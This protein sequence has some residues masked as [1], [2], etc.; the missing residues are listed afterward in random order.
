MLRE[1][2]VRSIPLFRD[3]TQEQVRLLCEKCEYSEHSRDELVFNVGDPVSAVYFVVSRDGSRRTG[4]ARARVELSAVAPAKPL[5]FDRIVENELFGEFEYFCGGMRP[6]TGGGP[7]SRLIRETKASL[8]VSEPLVSL[9]LNVLS[10]LIENNPSFRQRFVALAAGRLKAAL[11]SQSRRRHVDLD[12]SLAEHL[13]DLATDYATMYESYAVF[14]TRIS[15]EDI[16][17]DLGISRRALTE[18]FGT[19][20][21]A[22]L[23]RTTPLALLDIRRLEQLQRIGLEE[24]VPLVRS[25]FEDI[26]QWIDAGELALARSMALDFMRH[27]PSSPAL[28][29]GAAL[30]AARSGSSTDA[31][32]VLAAVGLTHP[33][34]SRLRDRIAFGL[35]RPTAAVTDVVPDREDILESVED[36]EG[37]DIRSNLSVR[38]EIMRNVTHFAG[39]ILS[40]RARLAKDEA[41]HDL[42]SSQAQRASSLYIDAWQV[43]GSRNSYPL[44][45]AASMALLAGDNDRARELATKALSL[46]ASDEYWSLASRIEA[47]LVL[48]DSTSAMGLSKIA[49]ADHPG[50]GSLATTRR[51]LKRLASLHGRACDEVL[52]ILS[53]PRPLVYSGSILRQGN[54]D[55]DIAT[56]EAAMVERVAEFFATNSIGAVHGA[57]ARGADIIIAE[58]AMKAGCP[59]HAVLPFDVAPF[60]EI[61]VGGDDAV[62]AA[63]RKR[64]EL[65]LSACRSVTIAQPGRPLVRDLDMSFRH[66]FRNA[67]ALAIQRATEL[68]TDPLLLTVTVAGKGGDVAGTDADLSDWRRQGHSVSRIEIPFAKLRAATAGQ[69]P[70]GFAA[71]VFCFPNDADDAT[72]FIEDGLADCELSVLGLGERRIKDGRRGAVVAVATCE[73]AARL[74]LALDSVRSDRP[75]AFCGRIICDYGAVIDRGGRLDDNMLARMA[76]G[77][78]FPSF[79]DEMVLASAP[80]ARELQFLAPEG[81]RVIALGQRVSQIG[82]HDRLRISPGLGVYRLMR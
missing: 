35:L 6:P 80:F 74:A 5:R 66:G 61:S 10:S 26:M 21:D 16:A 18:R 1:T 70:H 58:A 69:S 67:A 4:A 13:L 27:F 63:W 17:A 28:A 76:A 38:T 37:D 12:P 42:S 75:S 34:P 45:N 24:P 2:L 65:L 31:T 50:D 82:T 51:Q 46:P 49:M 54:L 41:W 36:A 71:T 3:L 78:D 32:N 73:A 23:L 62:G 52:S 15:Q 39:E 57:F 43:T 60:V 79:P 14:T 9:P 56:V 19:W 47:L 20:V 53:V 29:Y 7:T 8:L 25:V 81:L 77:G 11:I 59:V 22:G 44:A 72:R 68:E 48:G 40:L 33:D 64:F 30:A 55:T